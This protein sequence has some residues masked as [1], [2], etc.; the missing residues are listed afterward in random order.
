MSL[1]EFDVWV[2]NF[3]KKLKYIGISNGHFFKS[4]QVFFIQISNSQIKAIIDW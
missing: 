3:T 2:R 4:L 1:R